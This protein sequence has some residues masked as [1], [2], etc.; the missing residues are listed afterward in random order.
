MSQQPK[1]LL[2]DDDGAMRWAMR[3]ILAGAGFEVAEA[4]AGGSGLE[5][6]SLRTPDA[7]LLDMRMPGLDGDEVL[8]RLRRLVPNLPVIIVT[9]HG[10]IP[11]A[12]NA[13]QNGAFE[14]ITKPF[15]N[16]HLVETVRRALKGWTAADRKSRSGVAAAL[17]EV[18]G[19][20]QA[21]EDLICQVQA[22]VS[23]D[24]S[25]VIQG[26]T[27]TGKEVVA[28]CLHQHSRRA[29]RP[30]VVVDCG[31]IGETLTNTEFFGHEKGA[32]T[33]AHERRHGWFEAAA[34]GGT[35]FLDEVGNLGL[36]GQKAVLRALEDRT[37]YRV[38]STRPI[39]VD[40]RVIAAS[41][42]NL[43]ARAADGS[44]RED[45]FFRLAE[46]V[47]TLP[48]LR[49]RPG[50][51]PYLSRRFLAQACAA[52]GRPSIDISPAAIDLL[53]SHQ[54]PGNVR[55]LRNV[56]RRAVLLA[57]DAIAPSHLA[58]SLARDGAAATASQRLAACTGS[59]RQRI[60]SEVDVIERDAVFGALERAGGN[61]AEAAR[62][63]GVDY[64]T[65]RVKL[66]KLTERQ[67]TP[68]DER[69]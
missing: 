7:V 46:Y 19:Q 44:F 24:Y 48:P 53:Q 23:T 34:D 65:Y 40:L 36:A 63:L 28:R 5:M 62:L 54:W 11:G 58:T 15:R 51:I 10:T 41:N 47:I 30:L 68:F 20:G 42:D 17:T 59:L 33:G 8:R 60:R 22:V 50:D 69:A 39:H 35:I 9:G 14:Y 61:K 56:I 18:M 27:G 21:I 52:L 37:I 1:V 38:G 12:V 26:E 3:T 43:E 6:V 55:E 64:K 29:S 2:I 32:Y 66:K 13:M 31:T 45:L 16:E 67:G 25:V 57:S 4:E 49:A